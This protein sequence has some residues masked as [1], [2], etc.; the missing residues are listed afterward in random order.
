LIL[1]IVH[2]TPHQT[3]ERLAKDWTSPVYAFFM[4][5]PCIDHIDGQRVHVFE[6]GARHCKRKGKN[7]QQVRRYLDTGD[8]TSTSNLHCHAKICWGEPVVESAGQAK[9]VY[10]AQDILAKRRDGPDGSIT[11]AFERVGKEKVTYSH[12]QH[13]K[14]ESRSVQIPE[15]VPVTHNLVFS[16]EIVRWVSESQ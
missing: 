14:S 6:C 2:G 3:T 7:G 9:D 10:A 16:A 4:P 11:A 1:T 12:Q 15:H 8:A 5:I 13:T